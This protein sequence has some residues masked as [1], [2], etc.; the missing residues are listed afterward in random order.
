MEADAF[1][2]RGLARGELAAGG[3]VPKNERLARPRAI[4]AEA[5]AD[6]DEVG[7]QIAN[8]PGTSYCVLRR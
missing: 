2:T 8:A 1:V 3:V 7:G 6:L 5:V 4:A